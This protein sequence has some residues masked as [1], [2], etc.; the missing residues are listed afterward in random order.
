[1]ES[2][3]IY[4]FYIYCGKDDSEL[5]F[6][7]L[8]KCSHVVAKLS[9]HIHNKGGHK[10]YFDNYFTTLPLL[11]FLKSKQICVVGTIRANRLTDCPLAANEDLERQGRVALDYRVETNC[12]IIAAK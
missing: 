3:M 8:Q 12:G 11:H 10:L 9:K 5:K 4:D 7:D 6:K 2:G 1:M